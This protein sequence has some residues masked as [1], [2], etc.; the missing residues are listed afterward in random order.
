MVVVW[1]G[2]VVEAGGEQFGD[3][4]EPLLPNFI[5]H[6]VAGGEHDLEQGVLHPPVVQL[7]L[8]V[9]EA[10]QEPLYLELFR[11]PV[12]PEVRENYF[13]IS[14]KVL[15][16]SS[17]SMLV[18]SLRTIRLPIFFQYSKLRILKGSLQK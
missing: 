3:V 1:P 13:Y 12:D 7:L 8:G 17:S 11:Q 9:H 6:L 5:V 2:V 10:H 15:L 4:L 16:W 14:A 18:S